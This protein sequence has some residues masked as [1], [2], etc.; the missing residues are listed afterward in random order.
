MFQLTIFIQQDYYNL[1]YDVLFT[2]VHYV[3]QY[4]VHFTS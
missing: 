1:E 4:I 2:Y 3:S